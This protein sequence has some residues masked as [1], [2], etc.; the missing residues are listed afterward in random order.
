MSSFFFFLMIRRP[1][2]STLFPYTTLFRSGYARRRCAGTQVLLMHVHLAPLALALIARGAHVV[3][4]LYGVEVWRPLTTVERF[5][6]GRASRLVAISE[7][8]AQRFRES[9]PWIGGGRARAA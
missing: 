3:V 1:P 6:L 4:F 2:R 5:V 7:Y 9:N 8:T